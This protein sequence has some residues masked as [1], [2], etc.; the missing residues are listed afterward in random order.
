MD[1]LED[2]MQQRD[3]RFLRIDGRVTYNERLRILALF[4]EN[5]DI[6]VLLMSIET[7]SVG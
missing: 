1:L 5:P 4:S 7:G 2:L 6:A 3:I